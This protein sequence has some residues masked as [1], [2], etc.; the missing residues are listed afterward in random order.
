MIWVILIIGAALVALV[1][2]KG[3]AWTKNRANKVAV[4]VKTQGGL[5]LETT[6][7]D[8]EA[9][10]DDAEKWWPYL[11]R[12]ALFWIGC[13][14]TAIMVVLDFKFGISRA[15]FVGGI[16]LGSLFM[17]AD[18]ALP[19]VCLR[20]D[21]GTASWHEFKK[22]DRSAT[23]WVL[24]VL[25]TIM[26]V[27]VVIGSTAEVATTSGARNTIG[28]T[29]YEGT[30]DQIAKWQVEREKLPVDRGY[31]A[32]ANLAQATEEAADRESLR[33]GCQTKC[34]ALKKEA[35]TYRARANDAKR[36]EELTT[37]IAEA[38]DQL[39]SMNNVRTD[40]DGFATAMEDLSNGAVTREQT[41]K[42]ALT[43]FG[44][45]LVIGGTLLWMTIADDVK[46]KMRRE[47]LKRE[48]IADD[49]FETLGYGRKYSTGDPVALLEH[50]DKPT[51]D[52]IIV[53]APVQDMFKRFPNDADLKETNELF[54]T[55]LEA[56]EGGVVTIKDLYKAY[57]VS[58]LKANATAR[59]MTEVTLAQKLATIAQHRDDVTLTGDGRI[60]GWL[61]VQAA[62]VEA[63]E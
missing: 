37:K 40:N 63:A 11:E 50:D 58:V 24:I 12:N 44:I 45:G 9:W 35:A 62:A 17:A 59:Y 14:F 34:E 21:Q 42:H 32:L 31:E 33:G 38:Q 1:S 36:K 3:W 54:G 15:G 52:T 20:S 2:L 19:F 60:K 48:A 23:N 7:S 49:T 53:N 25:F 13:V 56:T 57:R 43:L 4:E 26:S 6:K 28:H 41:Q 8:I 30:L 39:R 18:L 27:F 5:I 61:L 46:G 29:R 51:G 22:S 16:I 55:L 10:V 47:R